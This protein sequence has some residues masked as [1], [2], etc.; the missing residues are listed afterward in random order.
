M[1]DDGA[2]LD[3]AR[4]RAKAVDRGLID[5]GAV[6]DD[7]ALDQLIFHPGFSTAQAVTSVSGR[8]VGMDVVKITIDELRGAVEVT[9]VPGR[10]TAVTLRLPLTL[11][12]IEG[13]LVRI[14]SGMFVVSLAAVEECVELAAIEHEGS[15][16]RNFL[17]IRGGLV[18]FLRLDDLFALRA[19]AAEEMLVIVGSD[20]GRVGLVVDQGVGHHQTVIKPLSRLHRSITG[21]AGATIL[22]TAGSRRSST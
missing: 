12:I 20:H 16:G 17:S 8:G 5:A 7:R 10:G 9:S 3:R 1:R 19:E 18:P 15:S 13:L 2:G 14:G 6:L 11:A 4:I 22:A 21:L